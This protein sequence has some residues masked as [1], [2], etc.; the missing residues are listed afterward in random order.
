MK[1]TARILDELMQ[2]LG[3]KEYVVQ[4]GDWGAM[5]ARELGA[6]YSER[7]KVMHLNWCPGALPEGVQDVTERERWCEERKGNWRTEHM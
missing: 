3:Y 7:C 5:V 2:R 1:D 6:K 4:A